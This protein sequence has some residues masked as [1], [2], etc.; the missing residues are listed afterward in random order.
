MAPKPPKWFAIG[1]GGFLFLMC[2]GVLGLL[3]DQDEENEA[4]IVATDIAPVDSPP[5]VVETPAQA[6]VVPPR[7]RKWYEGGTLTKATA[8]EWQQASAANKL[9]TCSDFIAG[10]WQKEMLA[11]RVQASITSIDDMKPFAFKLVIELDAAFEQQSDPDLNRK[12]Y[13]NQ[14]VA[15]TAAILMKMTGMVP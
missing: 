8:L 9:A 7:A 12:A 1:C 3:F 11:P 13:T 6:V 10:L 4:T 5:V 15:G 14:T 2:S